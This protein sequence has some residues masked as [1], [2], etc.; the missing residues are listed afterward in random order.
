MER[1]PKFS[2][3]VVPFSNEHAESTSERKDTCH[4]GLAD[5]LAAVQ[6]S[7]E[8]IVRS[9]NLLKQ[10]PRDPSKPTPVGDE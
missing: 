10:S 8:L 6:Q 9:E 7:E 4:D 3:L 2:E 1:N 5:L